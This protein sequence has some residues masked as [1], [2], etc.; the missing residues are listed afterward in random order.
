MKFREVRG[1]R[2]QDLIEGKVKL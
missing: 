2:I 1:T